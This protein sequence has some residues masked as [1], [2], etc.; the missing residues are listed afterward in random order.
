MSAI[1]TSHSS[2]AAGVAAETPC[3]LRG[4]G[5]RSLFLDFDPDD[6]IPVGRHWEHELRHQL[7]V[8]RAVILLCSTHSMASTWCFA[9]ITVARSMRRVLLPV[10]ID[11]CTIDP[12]LADRQWID[13]TTGK[14][15]ADE[16]LERS[17]G[18]RA[19]PGCHVG[20]GRKPRSVPGPVV[21]RGGRRGGLR[22]RSGFGRGA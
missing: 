6:G 7:R 9:E 17:P 19:R 10:G 18:R 12:I 15:A 20:L 1:F 21:V 4:I 8:R 2:R 14:V 11:D 5:D 3:W 13:M 16:R 22:A